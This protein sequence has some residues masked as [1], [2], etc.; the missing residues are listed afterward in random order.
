MKTVWKAFCIILSVALILFGLFLLLATPYGLIFAI[1]GAL[2][3]IGTIRQD[4]KA[5]Q[6]ERTE[7]KISGSAIDAVRSPDEASIET[8]APVS[9]TRII[10]QAEAETVPEPEPAAQPTSEIQAPEPPKVRV[11]TP[12]MVAERFGE[13]LNSIPQVEISRS[14]ATLKR[15]RKEEMPEIKF[16]NITRRTNLEKLF[17]VVVI[18]T[19]TTGFRAWS[20]RIIELSAIKL[21]QGFEVESCF[22]TLINPGRAIPKEASNVNRIT[23]GMVADAPTFAEVAEGFAAYI[24]GC[25]IVGH[26]LEFDL[27]FL[28]A[29]GLELPEQVRYYDTLDLAKKTLVVEGKQVYN[30]HTGEYEEAEDYDVVN[31]K[32]TTLCDY[33][34]IY[35]NDA[36]RSLS[37]CLATVK[38]FQELI[39][40]KTK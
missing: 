11:L 2:L 5:A 6:E 29:S 32:L 28:F 36:H 15:R 27:E 38:V 16:Y 4:R 14:S 37:D 9:E 26:N 12:S 3:L 10:S 13:E 19:E 30:H 25:G 34:G 8:A 20:E 40:D 35:R 17:P 1:P 24:A 22:T 21:G 39:H 18:D 33:Y 23:D 7:S 31:Y